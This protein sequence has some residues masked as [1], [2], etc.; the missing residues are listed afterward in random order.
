MKISFGKSN[1]VLVKKFWV[2]LAVLLLCLFLN[3]CF[4]KSADLYDLL[5]LGGLFQLIRVIYDHTLG[6]IPLPSIYYIAP[7]FFWY[8]LKG[9]THSFR[10]LLLSL[11]TTV[12]W[13]INLFYLLWGFNYNQPTIYQTLAMDRVTLDSIYIQ[14]AFLAQTEVLR[15]FGESTVDSIRTAQ[16]EGY[17]RPVQEEILE[18]WGIPTYGRVRIRKLPAGL[19]LRLRTSG[20][21]IPHAIEGHIDGGL[22]HKQ[23]PFTLAHEMGHGYGLTDESVCNFI[24]Y[25]T[26]IQSNNKFIRYS[27]E[28]AYWRYLAKYY[29]YYF[30]EEWTAIQDELPSM[31]LDDLNQIRKHISRY[32]NLMPVL[33]DV[34]YDNYLKSHGVRSGIKSYDELIQL[35]AAYKNKHGELRS[36]KTFDSN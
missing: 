17:I 26:C 6:F 24:A 23:I 18:E 8:F 28:L 22:Y 3:L 4:S 30:P 29:N 34:I 15:G 36:L 25:L 31:L 5:Y 12:I 2:G 14:K 33:R 10:S 19:L 21:Y 11:L 27:A 9:G 1:N 13:L 35:I 7:L 16:L 20:I 32:K